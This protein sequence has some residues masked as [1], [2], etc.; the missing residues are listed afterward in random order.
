MILDN[1][2]QGPILALSLPVPDQAYA[3]PLLKVMVNVHVQL[4][5]SCDQGHHFV[6]FLQCWDSD[7]TH[8]AT[9]HIQ[10]LG[11]VCAF[12]SVLRL[13]CMLWPGPILVLLCQRLWL[14]HF[15][16]NNGRWCVFLKWIMVLLLQYTKQK[17]F[18]HKNSKHSLRQGLQHPWA[19]DVFN[20]HTHTR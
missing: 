19:D 2:Q 5:I 13:S 6:H 14:S 7:I 15:G 10:C 20:K 11:P 12:P 8:Y 1:T 4:Y 17:Q 3:K 16:Y 9:S 18:I